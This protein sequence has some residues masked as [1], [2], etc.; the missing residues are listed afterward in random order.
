[1]N[2]IN[3]KLHLSKTKHSKFNESGQLFFFYIG[4]VVWGLDILIREKWIMNLPSFWNEYPHTNMALQ[5][6]F[7]VIIQLA[8]W[9]HN[10][11]ELYLQKVKKDEMVAKCIHPTLYLVFI[12]GGYV[13]NLSRLLI[14]LIILH[15][16]AELCFHLARLLYLI[17][18]ETVANSVFT[19]WNIVFIAARLA[20]VTLSVLTLWFGMGATSKGMIDLKKGDFNTTLVRAHS[21]LAVGLLQGW[22]MWNFINFHLKRRRKDGSSTDGHGYVS[23]TT[24]A[25]ATPSPKNKAQRR[26]GKA[27]GTVN[28][29]K[30]SKKNH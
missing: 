28:G 5:T 17:G 18:K 24:S 27:E 30:N 21:L 12:I 29:V 9:L 25:K 11:P 14:A 10:F 20:T 19:V 1:M 3:R 8:Y 26:T 16:V 4:S 6:K 2:K 23:S 15:Y 7:F 13:L 22:L